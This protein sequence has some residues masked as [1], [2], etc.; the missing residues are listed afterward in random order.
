MG[1]SG[2]WVRRDTV[3]TLCLHTRTLRDGDQEHQPTEDRRRALEP[4]NSSG[5]T[6]THTHTHTPPQQDAD[7]GDKY[8][9]IFANSKW[10]LVLCGG[11][12]QRLNIQIEAL[13]VLVEFL[14]RGK[15]QRGFGPG[16]H[17]N[18]WRGGGME[19]CWKAQLFCKKSNRRPSPPPVVL[20]QLPMG[21]TQAVGTT[22]HW[23]INEF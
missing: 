22:Q 9:R 1:S 18:G 10:F 4:N 7:S 13:E 21:Q 17:G 11:G 23:P 19:R 14:W 12:D 3:H 2:L 16:A 8:L 20:A 15:E 5:H 6:H